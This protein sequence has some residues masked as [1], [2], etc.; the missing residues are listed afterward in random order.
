MADDTDRTQHVTLGCG[1]LILIA[2]IVMFFSHSGTS[3]VKNE[4]QSL[5][6]EIRELKQSIDIQSN[7]IKMLRENLSEGKAKR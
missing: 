3:E 1:T 4:V 7:E 5:R 6:S 2:L